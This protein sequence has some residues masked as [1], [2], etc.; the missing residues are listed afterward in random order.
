[1][2]FSSIFGW[3][4][5][6]SV[7]IM[8]IPTVIYT[9][10]GGVQAVAWADVKQM[11]LVV[12]AITAVIAVVLFKLPVSP[13]AAL[14]AAGAVGRLRVFDFSFDVTQTYTFWSGLIGGMFLMLAYFGTDQ[15]QVQ[16]FLTAKS[17]D[18]ARSSL[19]I[20]A[21]WKIPLQACVLL[22]GVLVFVYYLFMPQ[23]MLFNPTH[24]RRVREAQPV[25]YQAL[26][27]QFGAALAQRDTAAR[28]MAARRD[29][30]TRDSFRSAEKHVEDVRTEALA[31]ATRVTG[32]SSR[33]VN[34]IIPH[35]VLFD[36]PVGLTGIFIAAVMAAAMSAVAGELNSLATASVIDFYRRWVRPN[37]PDTTY[38]RASKIATMIWGLFACFIA[39]YAVSLGSLI[40]VVNRFG[41]FFY[42][43][44]LGVFVLAMVRRSRARGAF[45]GLLAGISVV[46]AVAFGLPQVAFLW[47]NV[48][49]AV[50]VV[51]VGLLVS[52]FSPAPP[53]PVAR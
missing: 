10:V 53:T 32:E 27:S 17:V 34:Y 9:I 22:V 6:W 4:V 43:S 37:A 21:Y 35:F 20:S 23:P 26:A 45:V 51:V 16:R 12:M 33:D 41:S 8:G 39:A 38:V 15:S 42:G 1:V 44:I 31:L 18:E 25:A 11:V 7:A 28:A 49:G 14:H 50:T 19:L 48:I 40:E 24:D 3:P 46:G 29:A 5:G 36:L 2:V 47:H 30:G 52:A 13:E